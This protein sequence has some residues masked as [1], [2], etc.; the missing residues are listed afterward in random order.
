MTHNL[1]PLSRTAID[2]IQAE[3]LRTEALWQ[4]GKRGSK[5][6]Q[7]F[8]GL[9]STFDLEEILRS[10]DLFGPRAFRSHRPVV[11]PLIVITKRLLYGVLRTMLRI[12]LARQDQLNQYI[13]STAF[14][15]RRLEEENRRLVARLSELERERA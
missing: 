9:I 12:V 7:R 6:S 13:W 2:A 14:A 10:Q 1:P 15:V 5:D 4:P 8:E 3:V 11:G